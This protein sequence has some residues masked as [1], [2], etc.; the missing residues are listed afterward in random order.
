MKL[1]TIPFSGF[2]DSL[3][4][5]ELDNA[6]NCSFMD[7]SDMEVNEDL[8]YKFMDSVDWRYVHIEYSKAY[9]QSFAKEFSIKLK[10]ESLVCPKEYNFTTDRIFCH[11][12]QKEALRLY[13]LIDKKIL[14]KAI[15]DNLTSCS[16][17]HSSYPNTLKE[18]GNVKTWDHNQI[19][20][21]IQCYV[22]QESYNDFNHYEEFSLMEDCSGNGYIDNWIYASNPKELNRL[23][24]ISQYLIKRSE[25][26]K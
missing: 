22:N 17:F 25:R 7:D 9:V 6:V 3:H 5:S 11:I 10:F 23:A 26:V 20:T 8:K 2:Y 12:T 24:N 15:Y 14:D 18:W 1:T 16:G 21:L 13:K 19:G 4:D